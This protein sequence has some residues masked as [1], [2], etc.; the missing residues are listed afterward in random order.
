MPLANFESTL[1]GSCHCGELRVEFSTSLEPTAF[2]PRAC[3]CSF[4][5]KHGAAYI[6]DPVGRLDVV[7]STDGLRK[8]RQGSQT[9]EFLLCNRCGVLVVVTFEH[10]SCVYGAVNARCLDANIRLG[11]PAPVSPQVLTPEERVER[12]SR[13]WVP[14]VRLVATGTTS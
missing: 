3:D 1:F 4:C 10:A 7:V 11:N 12:W 2:T 8:Y 9:A 14:D 5:L 13:L 6:S